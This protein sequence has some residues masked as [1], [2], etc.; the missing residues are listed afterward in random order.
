[1]NIY[2]R[3]RYIDET[4]I[5]FFIKNYKNI[6]KL[7][8]LLEVKPYTMVAY[9]RLS[10]IYELS[11]LVEKK[12]MKGCFV[13]CGVWKGGCIAV[14]AYIAEK[15]K[16]NRKIWLFDSFEGLPEPT[17]I[18][19]DHAKTFAHD[20][21]SGKLSPIDACVS[22][23]EDV[24]KLLFSILNLN[25]ENIIF[26][27]GWFQ[28]ILPKIRNKIGDIAILRL[29]ADWY[30]STKACLDNLYDNVVEDGYVIIDDY[31]FW[32]GSK[33]ATDEFLKKRK[34][35]VNLIKI[36]RSG[37]YFEKIVN[38]AVPSQAKAGNFLIVE[39]D[40]KNTNSSI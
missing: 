16:S 17:S 14:M 39:E 32:E 27:K 3:F 19:G 20:K 36:D 40:T 28:N 7:K 21:T 23:I 18:D 29:D 5:F 13:E 8:L 37:V 22:P 10:N 25:K 33:K 1:M 2:R 30:E 9:P 38:S 12:K 6:E 31:N 35:D 11:E 26:Q 4:Q 24:K 34:L 15:H